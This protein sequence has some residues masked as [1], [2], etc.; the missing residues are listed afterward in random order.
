MKPDDNH[1]LMEK[2]AFGSLVTLSGVLL[3]SG[4]FFAF[5]VACTRLF[6]ATYYGFLAVS[7][8]TVELIRIACSLGMPRGGM[9][10]LSVAI[11]AKHFYQ[12]S[13]IIAATLKIPFLICVGAGVLLYFTA[14]EIAVWWF[15]NP[16]IG[17]FLALFSICLPFTSIIGCG[18]E[19]SR[20]FSTTLYATFTENIFLHG[21]RLLWILLFFLMGL[22][23]YSI[24]L[25]VIASSIGGAVLIVHCLKR[26]VK[27]L[28][29][30]SL[31]VTSF[32]GRRHNSVKY[33]NILAYSLPLL[34]TGFTIV[35]M[36]S[37]NI[38]MLGRFCQEREVGIYTAASVI[39]MLLSRLLIMPVNSILSPMV[40]TEF[41]TGR[42]DNIRHLYLTSTRWLCYAVTPIA[43]LIIIARN[44]IM[45]LF[46]NAFILE[47]GGALLMLTIGQYVN[48]ITGIAGTVLVMTGRQKLE[49]WANVSALSI[50]IALNLILIPRLGMI[51][52][53]A[54]SMIS[55]VLINGIRLLITAIIFR[56][57]P[58]TFRLVGLFFISLI[59]IAA[60]FWIKP[61]FLNLMFDMFY[62]GLS[63]LTIVGITYQLLLRD[64]D[65]ELLRSLVNRK[66]K[67][68][69]V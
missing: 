7:L 10:Y 44:P 1:A 57:Q 24:V 39:A 37:V 52:A 19:L 15:K 64:E 29:G 34:L 48:C 17:P 50:N 41:G 56:A 36:N 2:A 32:I 9:R 3:G 30:E 69:V 53:A 45:G 16:A 8:T 14:D 46:G 43:S 68:S 35:V 13:D 59:L 25:A 42:I 49:L 47:G 40:A 60:Y 63:F 11:G 18:V 33:K 20:G 6:G 23:H 65:K 31:A 38:I 4:L 66:M 27:S 51:G 5:Q 28:T 22:G 62:A 26:Q 12:I 61:F 58:I 54:S 67:R 21:S 55:Q